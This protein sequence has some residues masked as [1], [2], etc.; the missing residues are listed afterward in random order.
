MAT[1]RLA[2]SLLGPFQVTLDGEIVTQFGSDT[3]RALLAY[4]ALRQ[5]T[6]PPRA[7]GAPLPRDRQPARRG[8]GAALSRLC[9]SFVGRLCQC[10]REFT[11]TIPSST[12]R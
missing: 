8:L 2:I 7:G 12:L 10:E 1:E 9:L 5:G 6:D 4:L 11:R 3:A